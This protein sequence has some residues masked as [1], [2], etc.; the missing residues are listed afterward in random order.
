MRF[1]VFLLVSP[2][3]AW[4][5]FTNGSIKQLCSFKNYKISDLRGNHRSA[6]LLSEVFS[7]SNIVY[8]L[9]SLGS[10]ATVEWS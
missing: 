5:R 2:L 9:L 6:C 7:S 8:S 10:L 4:G 3:F 1:C